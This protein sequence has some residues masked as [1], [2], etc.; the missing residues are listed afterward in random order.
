M[1]RLVFWFELLALSSILAATAPAGQTPP[2][3]KPANLEVKP[4]SSLSHEIHHQLLVLP[5]YSVF[6]SISFTLEGH[7]VI[8]TGRVLR[9][10]LREHA[11]AAVKSIEGVAVVVNQIEVLPPSASDDDLR[12]AVYRALYEDPTLARYAV[13]N[14]PAVH[15]IIKNGAV[16][17]EG[18]VDS[19]LDKNL[20][21]AR[22]GSVAS[23]L[24]LKNNLAVH[25]QEG[26][27]E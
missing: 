11:E 14:I 10:T 18:S 21:A 3:K 12:D 26:A 1:R 5:F 27:T 8:L 20:A 13:Q 22:A 16:D 4:P 6:D 19:V 25:A 17:L 23:V 2:A 15:I 9:H 24:S 7:K